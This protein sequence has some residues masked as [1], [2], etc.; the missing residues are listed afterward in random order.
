MVEP[1]VTQTAAG[2]ADA[3]TVGMIRTVVCALFVQFVTLFDPFNVKV[4]NCAV[5]DFTNTLVAEPPV[6]AVVQAVS[7]NNDVVGDQI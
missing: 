4:N 1:P 3:D 6:Y 7:V 2:L 5:D